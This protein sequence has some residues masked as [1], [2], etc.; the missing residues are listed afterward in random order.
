GYVKDFPSPSAFFESLFP[1]RLLTDPN[2]QGDPALLGATPEELRR[3]KYPATSVP[4]VDD[5]M[6]ACER[7]VFSAATQ[8]WAAFD[9]YMTEQVAPWVPLL[10]WT[11]AEVVSSRVKSF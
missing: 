1:S 10:A 4:N 9:Q 6:A 3:W 11:G 7:V 2:G 8:C 5:R